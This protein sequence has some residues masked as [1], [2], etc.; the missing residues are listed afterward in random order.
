MRTPAPLAGKR[1]K[2]TTPNGGWQALFDFSGEK[3]ELLADPAA[4][5]DIR[6]EAPAE[7]LCRLL[8]GRHFLP[9]SRPQLTWQGG[10]YQEVV[11]LNIFG[12]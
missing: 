5:A 3:P 7:E 9:G 10:S 11:A 12:G 6:V 4:D 2:L 1:V 8:S